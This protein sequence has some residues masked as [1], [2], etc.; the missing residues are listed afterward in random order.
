MHVSKFVC[1]KCSRFANGD[2]GDWYALRVDAS[3]R[4]VLIH[5]LEDT[6]TTGWIHVC[7][8]QCAMSVVGD[9]MRGLP[10]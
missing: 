2:K 4:N 10:R 6:F 3:G 7:G 9:M 8:E 5:R 1:D